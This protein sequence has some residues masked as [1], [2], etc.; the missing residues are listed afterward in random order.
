MGKT[1]FIISGLSCSCFSLFSL[2][3]IIPSC[4]TVDCLTIIS[5]PLFWL[6][7]QYTQFGAIC[8]LDTALQHLFLDSSK[9]AK[10]IPWQTPAV[11]YQVPA[12]RHSM[13]VFINH[14]PLSPTVRPDFTCLFV[15]L[16]GVWHPSL[17]TRILWVTV[18]KALLKSR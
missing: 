1:Y 5:M 9:D 6:V 12:S 8:T 2:L 18:I 16:S 10:Q 11:L 15:H 4:A 14:Y 3:L 7:S 17:N 13:T